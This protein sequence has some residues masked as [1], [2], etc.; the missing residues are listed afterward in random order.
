[1][2]WNWV[3]AILLLVVVSALVGGYRRGITQMISGWLGLIIGFLGA[4]MF[5]KPLKLQ[6]LIWLGLNRP[7]SAGSITSSIPTVVL[8]ALMAV[9][10]F[11]LILAV[12]NLGFHFLGR[13]IHKLI[14]TI[15]LAWVDG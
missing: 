14:D 11:A 7:A 2:Q 4:I 1:M 10:A 9:V 5:F 15:G 8:S 12:V 3:D 13:G 6:L